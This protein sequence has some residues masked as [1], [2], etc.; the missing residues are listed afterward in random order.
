MRS[1]SLS[2]FHAEAIS[3]AITFI[4]EMYST[5]IKDPFWVV[6]SAIRVLITLARDWDAKATSMCFQTSVIEGRMA[7]WTRTSRET[8]VSR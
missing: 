5:M 2:F 4:F 6:A 3:S 8:E 1:S 7:T